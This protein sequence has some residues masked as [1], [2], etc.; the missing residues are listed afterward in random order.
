VTCY[1]LDGPG[2]KFGWGR[3]FPHRF[4]PTVGP[5]QP[6]KQWVADLF[7][8]G[9]ETGEWRWPPTSSSPEVKERV[10]LYLYPLLAFVA[11]TMVNVTFIFSTLKFHDRI[12]NSSSLDLSHTDAV[13]VLSSRF[14]LLYILIL[15]CHLCIRFASDFF[16]VSTKISACISL[17]SIHATWPVQLLECITWHIPTT[18]CFSVRIKRIIFHSVVS[19]AVRISLEPIRSRA[20]PNEGKCITSEINRQL[21]FAIPRY[22]GLRLNVS[23]G[24]TNPEYMRQSSHHALPSSVLISV[25][26]GE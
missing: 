7:P 17:V 14:F 18:L 4:R 9:K 15:Y 1:G 5:N 24:V 11:C 26:I 8:R 2:I 12:H 3:N 23:G 10:E 21:V 19:R 20:E 22:T 6:S 25:A 13:R 16:Y